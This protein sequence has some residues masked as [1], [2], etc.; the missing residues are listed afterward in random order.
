MSKFKKAKIS[1]TISYLNE[2]NQRV[3]VPR[4][5]CEFSDNDGFGPFLLR[6]ID[7]Q[8]HCQIELTNLEYSQYIS[9]KQFSII[10]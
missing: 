1:G 9:T 8:R 4:G 5:D 2:K 6:W 3:A 7:G 10:N